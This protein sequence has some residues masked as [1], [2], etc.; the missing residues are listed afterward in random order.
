[1][2]YS[3]K[4]RTNKIHGLP[5]RACRPLAFLMADGRVAYSK[6]GALLLERLTACRAVLTDKD[7]DALRPRIEASGAALAPS[8]HDQPALEAVLLARI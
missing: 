5:D 6:A 7:C 3:R 4:G 8:A 2:G 1:M